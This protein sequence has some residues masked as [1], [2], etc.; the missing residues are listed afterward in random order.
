MPDDS[1]YGIDHR[2]MNRQM[3]R[4]RTYRHAEAF[5]ISKGP[6]VRI[7]M[8]ELLLEFSELVHADIMHRLRLQNDLE[9]EVRMTELLKPIVF[10]PNDSPLNAIQ[11]TKPDS[12]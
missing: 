5:L 6:F 1:Q 12:I 2:A 9:W 3:E 4:R 11:P 8:A 7:D 10:Q